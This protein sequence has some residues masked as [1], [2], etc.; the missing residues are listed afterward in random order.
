VLALNDEMRAHHAA[1]TAIL[2]YEDEHVLGSQMPSPGDLI[3]AAV[4]GPHLVITGEPGCEQD[5]LAQIVHA[6][7]LLRER[8]LV[9]LDHA[10]GQDEL[11][12]DPGLHRAATIL[13]DLEDDHARLEPSFASRLFSPLFQTRVIALART[14]DVA[15]AA[16]GER[17]VKEMKHVCLEPLSRRSR[18]IHRL[19]DRMFWE[20]Q[21]S[22][23][24]SAMTPHNQTTLRRHRWAGN[25][26]SLREAADR[27]IAIARQGSL[28][29]AAHALDTA[30]A[31]LHN[32]YTNILGLTQP[33][34]S[35]ARAL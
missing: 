20:R 29:S 35:G 7:S 2:G 14:V 27:L 17:R 4:A 23:V 33:L 12:G 6:I 22:L 11:L 15:T 8:P 5:R 10:A 9:R 3:L 32:W 18:A 30:P 34:L 19:L 26:A 31:T 25:F 13:L 21:S 24:V 16:F 1:L 28:R